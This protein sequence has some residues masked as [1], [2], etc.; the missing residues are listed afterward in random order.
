MKSPNSSKLM[1]MAVAIG[2]LGIA[3]TTL[4]G[5][6]TG[7]SDDG[8]EQIVVWAR[9]QSVSDDVLAAA[10]KEFPDVEIK[11]VPSPNIDDQLRA[12]MRAKSG[13]PD[14]VFLG[15]NLTDYFEV[16]DQF[17]DIDKYGFAEHHDEYLPNPLKG[18]QLP[19][20][21]QLAMPTDIGAWAFFYNATEF[22]KLGFPSDPDEVAAAFADWDAYQ[23]FAEKAKASGKILCDNPGQ[24]LNLQVQQQGYHWFTNDNG[25]VV[26][27]FA[28]PINRASYDRAVEWAQGDLCANVSPYSPEWNAAITQGTMIAFA[29]PGYEMGILRPAAEATAGQWRT[30]IPTGGGAMAGGSFVTAMATTK[31]PETAVKLAEFFSSPSTQ[32]EAYLTKSLIPSSVA[33]YSD[34][35]VTGPDDFFGGQDAFAAIADSALNSTYVFNA[36][37]FIAIENDLVQALNNVAVT[38]ADPDAEFAAVEAKYKAPYG[39]K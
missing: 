5:C 21:T 24:V 27:D 26:N 19:D 23:D 37:G 10:K 11:F 9:P 6:A 25:S 2:A 12:A 20:G 31:H 34:P 22:D 29:G 7:G 28:N 14:V 36:P 32:I 3:A 35:K 8:K 17:L 4:T 33:A 38:G 30:A 15:G 16:A 39:E 18:G 13:I 1:R